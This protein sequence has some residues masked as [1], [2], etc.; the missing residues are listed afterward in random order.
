V[1]YEE[2]CYYAMSLSKATKKRYINITDKISEYRN[3]C[4][5]HVE[6]MEKNQGMKR[7]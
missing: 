1:L 3:K 7:I 5:E 2:S 6:R 4:W